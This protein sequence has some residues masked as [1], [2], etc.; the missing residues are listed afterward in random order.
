MLANLLKIIQ[1]LKFYPEITVY[2]ILH[3]LLSYSWVMS[4]YGFRARNISIPSMREHGSGRQP[5]LIQ[6]I[7]CQYTHCNAVN[8]TQE[9]HNV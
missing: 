2:H 8:M 5:Q 9:P 3:Q 7:A 6:F 1:R 4:V